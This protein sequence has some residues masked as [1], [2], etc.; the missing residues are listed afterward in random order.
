MPPKKQLNRDQLEPAMQEA[1]RR[2]GHRRNFSGAD[3][4]YRWTDGKVT[5]ELVVRVHVTRKLPE[6]EIVV[7][8]IF[9]KEIDGF[10]L[11]VIQGDYRTAEAGLSRTR[12]EVRLSTLMAGLSVGRSRGG[13]GTIGLFVIDRKTGRAGL[14]SNWHVL[15]GANA[16]VGDSILHPAPSD[17]GW[18][19]R[20]S[21][22]R[23]GRWMLEHDGDAAV[24]FLKP[25]RTWLPV[26]YGSN[27]IATFARRSR[28]GETLVKSG[29]STGVTQAKVDGE[30]IYRIR[31]EIRPGIQEPRDIA[32]FK[33]VPQV[34]GNPSDEE[35]SSPG[36]SGAVWIDP[37]EGA[38]V[39]LHFA[40]ETSSAPSAEEAIACHVD[41]VLN[42]L[43]VR[44]A[45][46]E[47][48]QDTGPE[49]DSFY[50]EEGE[51]EP[52]RIGA[53]YTPAPDGPIWPFPFPPRW[54][55][56]LPPILWPRPFPWPQPY[57]WPEPWP[58]NPYPSDAKVVRPQEFQ[59]QT[60][61]HGLE[62]RTGRPFPSTTELGDLFAILKEE[63]IRAGIDGRAITPSSSIYH[64][65]QIGDPVATLIAVI[66]RSRRFMALGLP[67]MSR[68]DIRFASTYY[69][70]CYEIWKL[71]HEEDLR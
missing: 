63:I 44:I 40:G 50:P 42:R 6:A 37:S 28:I 61:M 14:L 19:I 32:G 21:V 2:F 64:P 51:P 10:P 22:A 38:A 69:D 36:D 9:P 29:R 3:I 53:E 62:D 24:A 18:P 26:H 54:P 34:A 41:K 48:L 1:I 12:Q 68:Y 58:T 5:D 20:D 46:Y 13:A 56:P 60:R 65:G 11:D 27:L 39:G 57:P 16:R 47:D 7:S 8:E 23:L 31:Y 49:E 45:T 70:V 4:G 59:D 43:D 66:N 35:L 71:L 55:E 52:R 15:A 33:L 30:G 67:R 17:G 25:G